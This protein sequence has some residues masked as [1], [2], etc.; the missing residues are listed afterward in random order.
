MI[1]NIIFI[2]F[3]IS[4]YLWTDSLRARIQ[5]LESKLRNRRSLK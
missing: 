2:I 5:E 1:N 3:G 4:M